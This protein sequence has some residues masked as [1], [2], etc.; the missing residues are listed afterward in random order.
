MTEPPDVDLEPFGRAVGILTGLRAR[1]WAEVLEV[2]RHA[3]S[4]RVRFA[5][6]VGL[7]EGA[8]LRLL[9]RGRR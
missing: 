1:S 8:R 7:V 6:V 4:A 3:P 2:V 9:R 5:I